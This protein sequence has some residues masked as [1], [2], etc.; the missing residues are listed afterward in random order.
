[1]LYSDIKLCHNQLSL[2][3]VHTKLEIV[4]FTF[5]NVALSMNNFEQYQDTQYFN[6]I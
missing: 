2:I 3:T 5:H 6:C 4:H 1:M